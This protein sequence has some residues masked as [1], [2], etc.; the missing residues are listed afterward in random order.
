MPQEYKV[1]GSQ[2][3]GAE[4]PYWTDVT[5]ASS[6]WTC[7]ARSGGWRRAPSPTIKARG[8]FAIRLSEAWLEAVGTCRAKDTA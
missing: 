3:L 4:V 7:Q 5:V 1:E 2:S 8:A 6:G